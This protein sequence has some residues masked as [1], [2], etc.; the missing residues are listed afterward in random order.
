MELRLRLSHDKILQGYSFSESMDKR[1]HSFADKG[2][3]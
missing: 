1:E 2:N 3:R